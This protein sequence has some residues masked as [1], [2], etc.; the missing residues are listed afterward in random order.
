MDNPMTADHVPILFLSMG[1]SFGMILASTLGGP[2][3]RWKH[4][5]QHITWIVR[6]RL[7]A[8]DLPIIH[9][10]YNVSSL[11]FA[12]A[13]LCRRRSGAWLVRMYYVQVCIATIV[14][15]ALVSFFLCFRMSPHT[16][17]PYLV[18]WYTLVGRDTWCD[19]LVSLCVNG[20]D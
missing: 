3:F 17:I 20:R 6:V 13:F 5:F 4:A 18:T 14:H 16:L 15:I 10:L 8:F 1:I 7:R 11:T 19:D 12:L 2:P 9:V